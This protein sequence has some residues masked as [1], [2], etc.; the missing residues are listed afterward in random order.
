MS[1]QPGFEVVPV[2]GAPPIDRVIAGFAG[3]D[4]SALTAVDYLLDTYDTVPIANIRTK[5]LPDVAVVRDG[6]PHHPMRVYGLPELDVTILSSEV[7]VPVSLADRFTDALA[8][9]LDVADVSSFTLVHGAEFP[10]Q[11]TEHVP[12][13][14]A[15]DAFRDTIGSMDVD[16][17]PRGMLDGIAGE[18]L[19]RGQDGDLPP[20][21]VVV[22]PA[23]LPGPDVEAALS[24]LDG[25]SSLHGLSI[26]DTELHERSDRLR[27]YYQGVADRMQAIREADGT[28]TT[29]D[30]P[31]DRMYM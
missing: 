9:W 21:A 3:A 26:D 20:M 17:L 1:D 23:H 15:T 8:S 25:I 27:E 22:T 29:R 7:F 6:I 30:F 16:R 14:A 28:A 24:L 18:V 10:H 4:L 19:L 13:L 11:E 31:E 12:F 2:D 5:G